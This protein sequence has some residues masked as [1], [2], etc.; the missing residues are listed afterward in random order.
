MLNFCLHILLPQTILIL[1]VALGG[2][3]E[4]APSASLVLLVAVLFWWSFFAYL[5]RVEH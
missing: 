5:W 4:V 3:W 1:V 2:W